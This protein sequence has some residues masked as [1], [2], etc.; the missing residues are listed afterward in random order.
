MKYGMK[1][2]TVT[3]SLLLA[4]CV[5]VVFALFYNLAFQYRRDTA[6]S[7]ASHLIEINLQ[8]KENILSFLNRGQLLAANIC[9]EMESGVLKTETELKSYVR[10]HKKLWDADDVYLYTASGICVNSEGEARNNGD[11]SKF[12]FET[13]QAKEM[14]RLVKSQSEYSCS[15]KT[16]LEIQGSRIAAVSVIYDLDSLLDAMDFK[17][18]GG[19]GSVYLCRRNGVRI[20]QSGGDETRTV[21][22]ITSLFE[23]GTMDQL[24]GRY[25][26]LNTAMEYG[27]EDAFLYTEKGQDAEYVVFT[28]I[29]FMD[30]ELYLVTIMPQAVMNETL[31]LFSSRVLFLTSAVI[32][33]IILLFTGFFILYQR[34]SR[35]YDAGIRSR[36]R[37][38]DLLVSQTSNA[39]IL[40]DIRKPEPV[41]VSSNTEQVLGTADV[42]LSRETSGFLL[43]YGTNEKSS[44]INEVNAALSEWDGAEPFFS[45]YLPAFSP[46]QA[47]RYLRLGLYPVA[48]DAAEYIGIIRDA[49]PEY[50]REKNLEE[51]LAMANSANQAKTQFL[52]SVSHDIRTPLNAIINMSRFLKNDFKNPDKVL[53]EISVINQSSEHLLGLINDVLDLSRIESGKLVLV[54]KPFNMASMIEGVCRIIRPLCAAKG[55]NLIVS[56][57]GMVHTDLTGDSVRLNQI[58]INILNNAMKFTPEKGEIIFRAKELPSI[59]ENLFPFRFTIKDN[60][61]GIA[62]E[63]IKNIFS[64]FA[65]DNRETVLKTEGSGL[66]LAIT[67]NLVE[68]QGGTV[69]VESMI[70]K[71]S[72]FTVELCFAAG[73]GAVPEEKPLQE[74]ADSTVRFDG[75]HALLAED[76]QINLE[77]ADAILE[78]WGFSV[79]TASD[80][81]EAFEKFR[82][83][84]EGSFDII[85][86]DIQMPVMNGYEAA[87]AIRSCERADARLVPIVA[88]TANAFSEDV[89]RARAAGMNA[90]IA[91]PIDPA[92][93][94]SITAGILGKRR[95]SHT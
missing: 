74:K 93:V 78:Q 35:R 76:N 33:L 1:K 11:A 13:V 24:S 73:A 28:P 52:S 8:G 37:L 36:E 26:D 10:E 80:G 91:K 38:F 81:K 47:E 34:R 69:T 25:Q 64:P 45:G 41:Y 94:H 72:V 4:L 77:I 20:C 84:Q 40:F 83:S 85:Y 43:G 87:R 29:A 16:S 62:P 17:P 9:D 95:E 58:L 15:V 14:F 22:N 68:A 6:S 31:N 57:E 86:M 32:V 23:N 54:K 63:N 30:Q 79:A 49:T 7:G 65:R 56:T 50:Q 39:F 89:E 19:A 92:E 70:N 18:F 3:L 53:N 51:A 12:A 27:T 44:P 59:K 88:M 67:R 46:G 75:F 48:D 60:G 5:C 21:Y 61:I 55:Q 42:R 66:G 71:G 82:N 2:T 90:H